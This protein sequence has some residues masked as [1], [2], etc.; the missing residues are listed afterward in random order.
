MKNNKFIYLPLITLIIGGVFLYAFNVKASNSATDEQ[1]ALPVGIETVKKEKAELWFSYSGKAEA[2]NYVEIKPRVS[3][4]I[5]EIRFNE[6]QDVKKDDVLFVIDPRPYKAALDIAL[7]ELQAAKTAINLAETEFKRAKD[8]VKSDA[9][10]KK[11]L[12]E[13]KNAFTTANAMKASADAKVTQAKINYDYAF[14]KAPFSGRTSRAEITIG[15]LVDSGPNAPMLTSIVS[16]E[17][18]YIDFEIDEKTYFSSIKKQLKEGKDV[19]VKVSIPN[20]SDE[21]LIGKI[22]NLD[23]K[24]DT[25]SGTIRARALFNNDDSTLLP[26]MFASVHVSGGSNNEMVLISETAIGTDQS[27][28][29]V[30]VIDENNIVQYRQ[31]EVGKSSGKKRVV[32]SGLNEGERVVSEGIIKIRPNT[33]VQDKSLITDSPKGESS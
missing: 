31:I 10:S 19:E 3:G 30:W 20:S 17:G 29:F 15:N 28:K 14:V 27:R 24:I 18:I 16:N 9:I 26:G 33:K 21:E 7:A 2:V 12:D 8:L 6:G 4:A 22:F 11:I 23:N 32:L 25:N 13:R 1:Q 5:T